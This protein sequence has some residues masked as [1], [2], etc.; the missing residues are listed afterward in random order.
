M[1]TLLANTMRLHVRTLGLR[2]GPALLMIQGL[3]MQITDWPRALLAALARTHRVIV[4]DNRDYGRSQ[5]CGPA[6]D[7][8]LT[9]DDYPFAPVA[10]QLAPYNLFDMAADGMALLDALGVAQAHVLGFS[11]GGMVAQVMAATCPDRVLTLTSLMS[12]GGQPVIP[13]DT[14]GARH[15]ARMIVPVAD[16][17]ELIRRSVEAELIWSGPVQK[18]DSRRAARH[19]EHSFRR[20]Y[21]PAAIHR[22]A[23]A[24]AASG[25]RFDLLRRIACPTLILHGALDPVIPPGFAREGARLIPG[26][27]L[28]MLE[29][30]AHALSPAV[31]ARIA[32]EICRHLESGLPGENG[33]PGPRAPHR[34]P[35]AIP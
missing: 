35:R 8:A 28:V 10:P 32:P 19:L 7:P 30:G 17:A 34:I 13:A 16:R 25:A 26:A 9:E 20:C 15:L 23:L 11:L 21:R 27:R 4:F 33:M 31:L 29:T 18:I 24:Y 14:P 22:Q 1:P 5:L 3:G 2:D 6:I 12:S